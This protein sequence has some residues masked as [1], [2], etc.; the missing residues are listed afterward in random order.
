MAKALSHIA[1]GS[2][3][4]KKKSD[5][6]SNRN[7]KKQSETSS[8]IASRLQ[9]AVKQH[10]H[11]LFDLS[12]LEAERQGRNETSKEREAK[13]EKKKAN[14]IKKKNKKETEKGDKKDKKG[15]GR[16]T[17]KGDDGESPT[18]RALEKAITQRAAK[19]L[20]SANT[21]RR[22]GIDNND[23]NE[24]DNNVDESKGDR[25]T[26]ESETMKSK[27]SKKKKKKKKKKKTGVTNQAN[28]AKQVKDKKLKASLERQRNSLVEAATSA[29]RAEILLTEQPGYLRS[30]DHGDNHR[31]NATGREDSSATTESLSSERTYK[32]KQSAIQN[33]VDMTTATQK[34]FN[35]SL[36]KHAP[37]KA[38]WDRSGRYLLMGGKG[39]QNRGGH[40]GLFD[41]L[42][43]RLCTEIELPGG[44]NEDECINDIT[45]LHNHTM[46]A[47]AQRKFVYIYDNQ[48]VEL[49]CLRNHIEVTEMDF[50]PYHFLLVTAGKTGYLKWQ[51]T[52]TGQLV[53]EFRTRLGATQCLRS[54][55]RNAIECCGHSNGV[56]T[57]WSPNVSKPVVKMLAHKGSLLDLVVDPTG[58]YLA[59]SGTDKQLKIWDIRT[60]KPVNQYFTNRPAVSL[61]CSQRG[62]LAV[63][64]GPQIQIWQGIMGREKIRS[65][66]M[67]HVL[68][69]K[70][71]GVLQKSRR[72]REGSS[73][74][75]CQVHSVRF[76]PYEDVLVIGHNRGLSSIIVPGS[77][78]PNFDTFEANPYETKK[79]RKER[80]VHQLLDKLQ[81]SMITLNPDQIGNLDTAHSDVI[82]QERQKAWEANNPGRQR[83]AKE[84]KKMRGRS[85]PSKRQKRRQ[86]NIREKGREL[87]RE[88]IRSNGGRDRKKDGGNEKKVESA[89]DF[90]SFASVALGL[91]LPVPNATALK[92]CFGTDS[93]LSDLAETMLTAGDA[94]LQRINQAITKD[95]VNTWNSRKSTNI[96]DGAGDN[97]DLSIAK[98]STSPLVAVLRGILFAASVSIFKYAVHLKK[99]KGIAGNEQSQAAPHVLHYLLS[100]LH[101]NI[102]PEITDSSQG[103]EGQLADLSLRTSPEKLKLM[104]QG[105]GTCQ[106]NGQTGIPLQEILAKYNIIVNQDTIDEK[107]INLNVLERVAQVATLCL[108]THEASNFI[109]ISDAVASLS[110]E[111]LGISEENEQFSSF[112]HDQIRSNKDSSKSATRFRQFL[113]MSSR[114]PNADDVM[115]N[116]SATIM[117]AT[118]YSPQRHGAAAELLHATVAT[119]SAELNAYVAIC[120]Q[121][122][123]KKKKKKKQNDSLSLSNNS[124]GANSLDDFNLRLLSQNVFNALRMFISASNGRVGESKN[125]NNT[126]DFFTVEDT[127]VPLFHSVEKLA[128][129]L[130]HE[131]NE[132]IS[133]LYSDL[134]N[135][136]EKN[137]EKEQKKLARKLE[138][139][140]KRAAELAKAAQASSS[141]DLPFGVTEKD[142]EGKS[143][144]EKA[145]I[146]KKAKKKA[147]KAAKKAAKKAQKKAEKEAAKNNGGGGSNSGPGNAGEA[148]KNGNLFST[149]GLGT[150]DL[151]NHWVTLID[152][153]NN[154]ANGD[155]NASSPSSL[156]KKYIAPTINSSNLFAK[157]LCPF[158]PTSTESER[159]VEL[160]N[161]LASG[162]ADRKP[163]IARGARDFCGGTMELRN[164]CF[165]AI[166]RIF[167]RHGAVE[168]DTP[169]FELRETLT[170][171]YGEDTKLIY[172]LAEQGAGGGENLALRYD[173]TVPFARYLA[174]SGTSNIKRF[175]ISKVYRRDEVDIKRGRFRE[176]YQCDFDVAGTYGPMIADAEVLTVMCEILS[177]LPITSDQDNKASSPSSN[178]NSSSTLAEA[179]SASSTV[180]DLPPFIIK[181]NHRVL[182]DA[183]LAI[184]GVPSNK[185]RTI[186]SAVDK[187][188]KISWSEVRK[189]MVV[190]KGLDAAVADRIGKY[191]N[192]DE[193]PGRSLHLGPGKGLELCNLL[194]QETNVVDDW[195]PKFT[196]H[197]GAMSALKDLKKLFEYL[198]ATQVLQYFSFDLTLARGL[199]YYTGVIYEAILPGGKT[200]S[201]AA[202]GRYDGLVGMFSDGDIPCVGV[203]IGIE[204]VLKEIEI[205]HQ[206]ELERKKAEQSDFRAS[207][208][209]GVA[210]ST[211]VSVLVASVGPNLLKERMKIAK[212]LWESGISAEYLF[213]EKPSIKKQINRCSEG[214]IPFMVIVGEGELEQGVLK[215][216][217]IIAKNE[218]EIKREELVTTLVQTYN[219]DPK[220]KGYRE[221]KKQ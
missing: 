151:L 161:R 168:L 96:E 8:D 45:F 198:D 38:V 177:S 186:C 111:A 172:H 137:F 103:Q 66:Y 78:E 34:M 132:G 53:A 63:G 33:A 190:Q 171:K 119:L 136:A 206:A 35:L 73:R 65:P 49:H 31:S 179:S 74:G 44:M 173:L 139:Q 98:T 126:I 185:F 130:A 180:S 106:H 156:Q 55:P 4:S 145:K 114:K 193:E 58:N 89:L 175:H 125:S 211:P 122:E 92:E 205:R 117:K 196:Q 27:N 166:R 26:M 56:V 178:N 102:L 5:K 17:T 20:W 128:F 94:Q 50:L 152:Q 29:A 213:D 57:M 174:T 159:L 148:T 155:D 207:Y 97:V 212:I 162:G 144:A 68:N 12:P 176:F 131:A 105:K 62:L 183:M 157:Y 115:I 146:I 90:F 16:S 140:A 101:H 3:R 121:P 22:Q 79:Q 129:A 88:R 124:T 158:G 116:S 182:L 200:G 163:R 107:F 199:D 142:L 218:V 83:P 167:R 165:S 85:R 215:I 46:W 133:K 39:G 7:G 189:E 81:P 169:V 1:L 75:S 71:S 52:S 80:T 2:R 192:V 150:R 201:I 28:L 194:M 203:S 123:K 69:A 99:R 91:A 134:T 120:P 9:N 197:A 48:G 110:C 72:G 23:D 93:T 118:L 147:E 195:S 164:E 187:L 41:A 135:I 100:L 19:Y 143:E 70:G 184:C 64:Q 77:G 15:A 181:L 40:C 138:G 95:P 32:Y 51:D 36:T 10:E 84:R 87:M 221:E 14:R 109:L 11:E 214:G 202:G 76:R 25:S 104:L 67:N 86:E 188:D 59:T 37:Y 216:K 112:L 217:D 208:G 141:S 149:L 108:L 18:T 24:E 30:N 209:R 61:D 82:E 191:V 127:S 21:E 153:A 170:G 54:N 154:A 113:N 220:F 210:G 160:A 13:R 60:Y 47:A 219:I 204:R 43:L 6:S 42:D